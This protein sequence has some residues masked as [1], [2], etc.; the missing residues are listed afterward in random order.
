MADTVITV[1]VLILLFIGLPVSLL[2]IID[3]TR[4]GRARHRA[5]SASQAAERK[6]YERRIL[7][8]DWYVSSAIFVGLLRMHYVISTPTVD[9]SHNAISST[10][11]IGA[12]AHL[13]LSTRKP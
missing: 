13:N 9:W 4:T 10:T 3:R 1:L 11:M 7:A 8:P 6:A 2:R 5:P 12:L